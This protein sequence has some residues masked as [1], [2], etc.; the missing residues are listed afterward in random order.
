[1]ATITRRECLKVLGLMGLSCVFE[2][3]L[4]ATEAAL[5]KQDLMGLLKASEKKQLWLI[6]RF[7]G[8]RSGTVCDLEQADFESIL[9]LKTNRSPSYLYEYRLAARLLRDDLGTMAEEEALLQL[10]ENDNAFLREHVLLEY[11]RLYLI[12]G[13]YRAFG[14]KN[15]KGH[16]GGS[17]T[18]PSPLPYRGCS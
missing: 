18:P 6:F 7:I 1:M 4:F 10:F 11:V 15:F 14:V 13:G 3:S 2:P 17:F 12:Y 9:D 16:M 5:R 8:K